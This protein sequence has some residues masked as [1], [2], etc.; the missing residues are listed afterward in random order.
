M[1]IQAKS[2]ESNNLI[3]FHFLECYELTPDK[4]PAETKELGFSNFRIDLG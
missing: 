1:V 4:H 3:K 2:L